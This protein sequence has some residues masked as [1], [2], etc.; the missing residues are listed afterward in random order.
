MIILELGSGNSIR[1]VEDVTRFIDAIMEVTDERPVLK[2]QLFKNEP[3][4]K[5]LERGLFEFAYDYGTDN[6]FPVT[7]SVFDADDMAFLLNFDIPFVK[8][9]CR[10]R[11]YPLA[12]TAH[13][14]GIKTV[15][16]YPANAEM[17]KSSMV[18]PL[19]CVPKY[20]AEQ[21]EY[22]KRF[23]TDWLRHG[24][25]DHTPGFGLYKT[26]KPE[27]YEKHIVME[28][29]EGNPDAGPFAATVEEL[30]EIL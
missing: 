12:R 24:I 14:F 20:P 27:W 28:R 19:C 9:A 5:P 30:V 11:L 23:T 3:P 2:F 17:G 4:N 29:D 21:Y 18:I 15:V 16:S 6:G 25:S 1:G 7:A 8:I 10:P 22:E 13:A 26:Y